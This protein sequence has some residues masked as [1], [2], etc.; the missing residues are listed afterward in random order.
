MLVCK[1]AIK[2]VDEY[3]ELVDALKL[4]GDSLSLR[5][6]LILRKFKVS[7]TV[8]TLESLYRR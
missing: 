5:I 8:K 7:R 4:E 3:N 1:A 6:R 2:A